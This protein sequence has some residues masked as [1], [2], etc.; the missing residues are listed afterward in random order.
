MVFHQSKLTFLAKTSQKGTERLKNGNA[1]TLWKY[2]KKG[3]T[4]LA[5]YSF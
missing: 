5:I 2:K 4:V 3:E 1:Y